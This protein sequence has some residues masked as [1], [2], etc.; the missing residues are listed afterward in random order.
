MYGWMMEKTIQGSSEEIYK[1]RRFVVLQR[2]I[3]RLHVCAGA[4]ALC[5]PA[6]LPACERC[7]HYLSKCTCCLKQSSENSSGW[8]LGSLLLCTSPHHMSLSKIFAVHRMRDE[9]NPS[10]IFP[11]APSWRRQKNCYWCLPDQP[12]LSNVTTGHRWHPQTDH[13]V[14]SVQ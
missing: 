5:L 1:G 7:I 11:V 2:S 12:T 10:A 4:K 8:R 14:S 6:R 13:L 3:I 9:I